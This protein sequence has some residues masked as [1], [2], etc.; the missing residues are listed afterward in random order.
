MP[1]PLE[2]F[3][4]I[5]LDEP[6]LRHLLARHD[7][8]AAHLGKLWRY[9]RNPGVSLGEGRVRL[10]QE[11]GLPP[12]LTGRWNPLD[13]DRFSTEREIVIENDIAWRIHTL[14]DF[15]AGRPVSILS[16]APDER[17]RAEIQSLLDAVFEA[18]GGGALLQDAALLAS[19]YGHVDLLIRADALFEPARAGSPSIARALSRA[20]AVRLEPLEPT[21]AVP[22]VNPHDFRRLDAM[23][24]RYQREAHEVERVSPVRRLLSRR[25]EAPAPG[26]RRMIE[27]IE[28]HSADAW[29][30]FEDEALVAEGAHRL[31]EVPVVHIQNIAQPFSWEG[32]SDVE[33]L[34]PLQ[35]ELNTRLS[36]RANRV[37]MQAFRMYLARGVDGFADA[38]IGPGQVFSTDNPDA[39]IEVIGADAPSP[40]EEAHIEGLREAL[41]KASSVTP[42]AAGVLRAGVGQLSSENALRVTL[43]GALAKTARKQATFGRALAHASRLILRAFDEAGVYRTTE[44]ERAVR[45]VW[46]EPV[47]A[48]E[49]ERLDGARARAELGVPRERVLASIGESPA[50]PGVE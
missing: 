20:G 6:L 16:A 28:V 24:L 39:S 1:L 15:L 12:R 42:I 47:P 31:G 32:L 3:A 25:A 48:T 29:R 8:R 50:D 36:D 18:S 14:V 26:S 46:P 11:C 9:Y 40:S 13:D 7:A 27:V 38:P 49:R 22:L 2:P 10:A 17:R 44:Q 43:L 4:S 41:D 37:T 19:V 21:R 45:I 34:I 35:D 23:I 5:P 30:R 33:P